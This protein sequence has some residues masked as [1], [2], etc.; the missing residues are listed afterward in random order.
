MRKIW[1]HVVNHRFNFA[2]VNEFLSPAVP[3]E[4]I[5]SKKIHLTQNCQLFRFISSKKRH[6]QATFLL[7]TQKR[8]YLSHFKRDHSLNII[9]GLLDFYN[10]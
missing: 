8:Q 2:S 6:N 4:E 10:L 3:L 1:S 5:A 7:K 9:F